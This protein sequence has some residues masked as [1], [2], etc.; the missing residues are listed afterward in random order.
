MLRKLPV[1]TL[2]QDIY[3]DLVNLGYPVIEVS[4]I[5]GKDKVT[6]EKIAYP[7]FLVSL[8]KEPDTGGI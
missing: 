2:T 4:Q 6:Q 8:R 7:L 5:H 3:Q 1:D